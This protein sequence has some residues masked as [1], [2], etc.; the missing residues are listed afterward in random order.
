MKAPAWAT[1]LLLALLVPLSVAANIRNIY[2]FKDVM[3]SNTT[4]ITQSG[5]NSL[6]MFGVGVLANGDIMYYS[7]TPGSKDVVVASGGAYVGGAALQAKVRSLKSAPGSTVNRLEICM[8]SNNVR[9]LMAS[10][11][12]GTNTNVYRNFAALKEA[13]NLDAVN[14]NDEAIYEV[15]S[16][17]VFAKMLGRMGYKYAASPYT[18]R[19][20]YRSLLAELN[21]GLAEKD[22]LLDR[23]YLQCYDGGAGN[24]PIAWQDSLG[25]KMVP[26]LWVINDS[27]PYY[28]VTPA[29]ARTRF[30]AWAARGTLGGGGYWNEYDIEKMGLSYKEYSGVLSSVF[31]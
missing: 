30:A 17:V 14:N 13:W 1:A 25:I 8:N 21:R 23:M 20:F 15:S 4:A 6:V 29:E 9:E 31:P 3:V 26:L 24:D 10:P 27:K 7:N 28:G 19:N 18:N 22:W 2:L 16:T 11:G 12:P 5:F